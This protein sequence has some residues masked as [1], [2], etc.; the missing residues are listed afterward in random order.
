MS[1]AVPSFSL[2]SGSKIPSVGLGLWKI[3]QDATA[4]VVRDAIKVGY[5]H[6][7]AACDYGN[8]K[9]AGEGIASAIGD[10]LASRD[11]L[12]VTSK[13]W[14]T[15]HR[16]EHVRAA[17]ERSLR[18][19]QLEHL[20]L[21]LMHFPISQAFVP[22][23][24][25]Y[26]PGW[27]F[28]PDAGEPGIKEDPVPI[29]ET[30]QAM[31]ELV[32]AGLVREIGVCNFGTSLLRDLMASSDTHPAVLQIELHP[33]LT[34]NKLIRFCNES[35]IHVTGFSPLGALSYFSLGMAE[36][37]ESVIE[38]PVVKEIAANHDRTPAQILLRWGVQRGTSVVPKTSRVE[39]LRENLAIADI[40]L[41]DDEMNA[42]S[43]LDRHRRFNDPGDFAE[44][45]FNTF[46]PI[47]E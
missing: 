22:F 39:R 17:C 24:K 26:P 44:A 45:A 35:Q 34:Q 18:D 46:Y 21:Y 13:L 10:G 43:T 3:D 38:Q 33:Y 47:Y 32:D 40:A 37:A 36:P 11:D 29:R 42:I 41:T 25:R 5:R 28:D 6:L 16:P 7:D 8:E 9:Q 12:W 2:R 4:G 27:F 14:N 23:E 15:Y 31:N 20:D 19:L 1:D 30:W